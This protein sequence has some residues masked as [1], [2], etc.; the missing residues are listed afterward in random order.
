MQIEHTQHNQLAWNQGV[1]QAWLNRFGSPQE[2]A[3]KIKQNPSAR[4]GSLA[5]HFGDVQGAKI[6]NLM[7]SHGMKAVALA[8]LG[9]D[10]T[11]AD[12]SEGNAQYAN[13]LAEAA[14]VPLRYLVTD[15][16]NMAEEELTGAYDFVFLELGILHYFTDLTPLFEVIAKLLKAGGRLILQDFHPVSTKLI[17]SRGTTANI[18]K[19][20]VSG[21]YF[22]ISIE[23]TDISFYKFLPEEY[24]EQAQKVRLRKWTLGEIVTSVASSGLFIQVLEEEANS[25]S[26]VFD[27]EIPK[28]F[29]IVAKKI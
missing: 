6:I 29:V 20:K 4:L 11:V 19:H 27:K 12:F 26:E 22:D 16:L 7:G 2:I 15:V 17:N 21:N 23:E 5:K 24:R 28:T 9:A 8:H 1:Y 13:E 25:S 18:R 10:V 14:G 3:V